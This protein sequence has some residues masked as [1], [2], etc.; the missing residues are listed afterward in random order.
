MVVTVLKNSVLKWRLCFISVTVLFVVV[1]L[2]MGGITSGAT[3]VL[4]VGQNT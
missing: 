3:Y 4:I 2:E 1:S